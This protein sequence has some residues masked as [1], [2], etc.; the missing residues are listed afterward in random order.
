MKKSTWIIIGCVALAII[1]VLAIFLLKP[2][3]PDVPTETTAPTQSAGYPS[4]VMYKGRYIPFP[5]TLEEFVKDGWYFS[6]NDPEGYIVLRNDRYPEVVLT[7]YDDRYLNCNLE[8]VQGEIYG[9]RFGMNPECQVY[10]EIIF[11]DLFGFKSTRADVEKALGMP[12]SEEGYSIN[13]M[14]REFLS[15]ISSY[16]GY[17]LNYNITLAD[18]SVTGILLTIDMPSK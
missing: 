12:V 14:Y 9:I 5:F 17:T 8:A 10:P 11:K 15:F 13:G 1:V 2:K 16:D 4:D 18:D 7:L 6:T 3:S